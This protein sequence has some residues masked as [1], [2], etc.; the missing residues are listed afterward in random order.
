MNIQLNY[1]MS[2]FWILL[3]LPKELEESNENELRLKKAVMFALLLGAKNG[4]T[5]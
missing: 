5:E 1:N 4:A 2:S 3:G